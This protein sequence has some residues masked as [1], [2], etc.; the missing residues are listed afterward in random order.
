MFP[1]S[2]AWMKSQLYCTMGV[3]VFLRNCSRLLLAHLLLLCCIIRQ[4]S[5]PSAE[6]VCMTWAVLSN[7]LGQSQTHGDLVQ[8]TPAQK[9]VKCDFWLKKK[10]KSALL[11]LFFYYF[12][13]IYIVCKARHWS[14]RWNCITQQ[15][16]DP[17]RHLGRDS[18]LGFQR[19]APW[20][21]YPSIRWPSPVSWSKPFS[22]LQLHLSSYNVRC[23]ASST[24]GGLHQKVTEMLW[25]WNLMFAKAGSK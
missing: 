17:D 19:T 12:V 10:K 23:S 14:M 8:H 18:K 7:P 6:I 21:L 1:V 15:P 20:G 5:H 25:K 16:N 24:L 13:Y 3:V 22:T 4:C 9:G 2:P 11:I